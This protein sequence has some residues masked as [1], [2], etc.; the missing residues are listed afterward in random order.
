M[1]VVLYSETGLRHE[2]REID[3]LTKTGKVSA[4]LIQPREY[5]KLRITLKDEPS[6]RDD[7][8]F[9]L[10]DVAELY[11]EKCPVD[12]HHEHLEVPILV[13]SDGGERLYSA[14]EPGRGIRFC[15]ELKELEFRISTAVVNCSFCD[16]LWLRVD[17]EKHNNL[18]DDYCMSPQEAEDHTY[19][20]PIVM[21]YRNVFYSHC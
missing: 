3:N 1:E 13:I 15:G 16:V 7:W 5:T 10:V 12:E 21:G 9:Q 19:D 2:R 6:R 18:F 20:I 4:H 14:K 11:Q 8:Y 17:L